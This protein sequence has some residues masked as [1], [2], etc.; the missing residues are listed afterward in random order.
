[1]RDDP[2]ADRARAERRLRRLGFSPIEAEHLISLK[3]DYAGGRL[4]E[5]PAGRPPA[6]PLPPERDGQS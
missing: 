5:W 2:E 1:M 4:T 6:P 3:V